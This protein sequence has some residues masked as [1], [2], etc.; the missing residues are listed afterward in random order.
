MVET[1]LSITKVDELNFIFPMGLGDTMVFCGLQG[2]LEEQYGAKIHFIIK[3]VHVI[4]MRMYG[5]TNYS[6]HT[7]TETEL[8]GISKDNHEPQ[9]GKLYV[10]H[11]IYSDTT[12]L[13]QQWNSGKLTWKQL[14]YRF[15]KTGESIPT[16]QPVWY[17]VFTDGMKTSL[18]FQVNFD[19]TVLLLPEART[20][21]LLSKKFWERLARKLRSKGYFITQSYSEEE[22]AISDVPILP[23]NMEIILAFAVLCAKVYSLRNGICDLIA[24]NAK[25][26]TVYHPSK[27]SYKGF[28][29]ESPRVKNVFIHTPKQT[30]KSILKRLPPGKQMAARFNALNRRFNMLQQEVS[31]G[32]YYNDLLEMERMG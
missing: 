29:I 14:V 25:N 22:S 17:P 2:V 31:I 4:V 18:N 7:F 8:W 1:L 3:P 10:A 21:P 9:I 32:Q 16:K 30:F 5:N 20:N 15:M 27:L 24:E 26:L 19:K 11:P 6:I 23:D 13:Q 28:F 12:G